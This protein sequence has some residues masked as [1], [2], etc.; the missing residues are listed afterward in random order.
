MFLMKKNLVLFMLLLFFITSHLGNIGATNFSR[1]SG[2]LCYYPES[3]DFGY[4]REGE[5]DSTTF[6]IW[7]CCDCAGSIR[8]TLIENCSWVDVNPTSGSSNGEKDLI[9]VNINTTG[10]SEGAYI[11]PIKIESNNG[12]GVF[13]VKV[14]IAEDNEA[15]SVN[16][17]EPE[18]GWLYLYGEKK[19]M[20]GFTIIIGDV[21]IEAEAMDE[22][23][24]IEKVNIYI[25][26]ELMK[27][28]IGEPYTYKW[29][30]P[31][32]GMYNV[33]VVAYDSFS[34]TATDNIVVWKFL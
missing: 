25:G 22:K 14:K 4:K 27:T 11:C 26:N 23:T 10:L 13:T 30:E 15:P 20:V 6:E 19:I 18:R 28:D 34:N 32:F 29:T 16:I 17:V 1:S 31:G 5:T 7:A 9:T 2:N 24:E 12:E 3:H 21:T 8:Y 33:K